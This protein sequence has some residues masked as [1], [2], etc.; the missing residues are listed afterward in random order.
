MMTTGLDRIEEDA[1]LYNRAR[2]MERV[3]IAR[4]KRLRR[5]G[6]NV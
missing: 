2:D 5:L 1:D 4:I 3:A 6:R